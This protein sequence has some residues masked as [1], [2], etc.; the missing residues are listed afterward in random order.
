MD[1]RFVEVVSRYKDS[2]FALN[3]LVVSAFVLGNGLRVSGGYLADWLEPE[4]GDDILALSRG[5][6]VEDVIS[7][8]EMAESDFDRTALG[9]VY[10]PKYVREYIVRDVVLRAGKPVSGC[11]CADVSCGCGAFLCTLLEVLRERTG[12]PCRS[13]L[14]NLYG[15]DINPSAVIRAKLLLSLVCLL[16]GEE[17]EEYDLEIFQGDSLAYDFKAL[18]EVYSNGGFDII[19]GNPPYV[20]SK[21]VDLETRLYM[22]RWRT[23][24]VGKADLYIPFFEIGLANLNPGGLL[25]Y[26]T[27]NTFF[28]S[29]NARALREYLSRERTALRIVDFGQQQVFR[30]FQ[31]YTCLVFASKEK[32]ENIQY[33]RADIGEI[34]QM[35]G[36]AY[37]DIAYSSLDNH[38]GWNLCSSGVLGN[39]RRIEAAGE[40]LGKRYVIKGG[41]ATLANGVFIFKPVRSDGLYYYLVRDGVEFQIEKG[42]CRDIVKPN[43]LKSERDICDLMEKVI[44][45]YDADGK[46][47]PEK[48]LKGNYPCAYSYL[49]SCRDVLLRRDK[50]LGD[51]GAWYAFGRSQA[52]GDKGKKLLFPAIAS[53][54]NFVCS[55]REDLMF[56]DGYAIYCDSDEELLFLKRVLES[57]VMEYYI[58]H[59]SKPYS[60][61]F[62][63]YAKNYVRHFGLYPFTQEQRDYLMGLKEKEEVDA[64]ICSC[65]GVV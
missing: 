9:I 26:I 8:F 40:A 65:Y 36:L 16:H 25:G 20:S 23:T 38:R 53:T 46:V 2:D 32:K 10:T 52:I 42:V 39:I 50:G 29:V 37:S 63:S 43:I 57:F 55:T 27:V 4:A 5:F 59:T 15:I 61:G 45:P 6:S 44:L 62:F 7:V 35:R 22:R 24:K 64:F 31:T 11:L 30:G 60:S 17:V 33:A 19:V 3:R 13:I 54:P 28:K 48:F 18:P 21:W 41:I 49:S 56:Y 51:Y 58:R 34:Q 47:L 14:N 1:K 12:L